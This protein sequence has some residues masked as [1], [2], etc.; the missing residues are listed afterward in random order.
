[1]DNFSSIL[2]FDNKS[3]SDIFKQIHKN[4]KDTDKQISDL[5]DTL[6]PIASQN[7]GNA[8]MLMPTVKDLIDVNVK[9]NEQLIKMAAIAQ[10]AATATSTS[11]GE[12]IN[13]DEIQD[14]IKQQEEIR[15]EG[16]KL[17]DQPLKIENK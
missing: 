5:I 2:L 14:L 13:Y 16:Q 12:L 7:A 8:V 9:N 1:M 4:N 10:R 6:K 3:L 17:L 11:Q 15:Q